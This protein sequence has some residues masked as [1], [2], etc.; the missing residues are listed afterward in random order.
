MMLVLLKRPLH[1]KRGRY[2]PN[3]AGVEIP[4]GTPL[5]RDAKVLRKDDAP[6]EKAK[7]ITS[8]KKI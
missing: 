6:K 4:E 1:T 3:P 5:P 8:N 7:S 2:K